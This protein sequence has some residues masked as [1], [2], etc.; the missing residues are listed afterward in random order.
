MGQ[1]FQRLLSRKRRATPLDPVPLAGLLR[2]YAGKWVAIKSGEVVEVR[3]TPDQLVLALKE[4]DIVN[5][6]IIRS[7]AESEPELVGLG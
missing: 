7:P 1:W 2:P 5:A 4:R 3:D 6:T